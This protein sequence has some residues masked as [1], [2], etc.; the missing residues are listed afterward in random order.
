MLF[1]MFAIALAN[2]FMYLV[3]VTPATLNTRIPKIVT[4][5][6]ISKWGF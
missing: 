2:A 5:P 3:T 6:S 1:V 4:K